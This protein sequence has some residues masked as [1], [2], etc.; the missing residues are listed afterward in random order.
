M[1]NKTRKKII[2]LD[3]C[4]LSEINVNDNKKAWKKIKARD[5]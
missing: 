3:K 4:P 1:D 2:I 5:Y